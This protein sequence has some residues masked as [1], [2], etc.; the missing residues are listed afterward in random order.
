MSKQKELEN[1]ETIRQISF[2]ENVG[3]DC[4]ETM[5]FAIEKDS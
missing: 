4:G 2:T 5:F 1:T 3:D